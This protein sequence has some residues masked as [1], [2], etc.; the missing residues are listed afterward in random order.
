[1]ASADELFMHMKGN[2]CRATYKSY[3]ALGLLERI[4][5]L[6]KNEYPFGPDW[7]GRFDQR[8]IA[9]ANIP[10]PFAPQSKLFFCFFFL[11]LLL[12]SRLNSILCL[13][14]LNLPQSI[15]TS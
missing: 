2:L 10:N 1:M 14:L 7:A 9:F 8:F 3:V 12:Y 15:K 4:A 6:Q 13:N 11:P 5:S